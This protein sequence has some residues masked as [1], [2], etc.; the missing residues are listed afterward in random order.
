M[1]GATGSGDSLRDFW[2]GRIFI[3]DAT[4]VVGRVCIS[5]SGRELVH[6]A[7]SLGTAAK[8]GDR[9]AFSDARSGG[10][11]REHRSV[12]R[13][14]DAVV[15]LLIVRSTGAFRPGANAAG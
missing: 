7:G 14:L 9:C 3:S 10:R 6:R 2:P 12:G 1:E 4:L 5:L 11:Q 13:R 8:A 15:S